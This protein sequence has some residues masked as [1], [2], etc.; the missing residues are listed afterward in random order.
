MA[1]L[2]E[3]RRQRQLRARID[4]KRRWEEAL[5]AQEG[6]LR[7]QE[8]SRI[9]EERRLDEGRRWEEA[10]RAQESSRSEGAA[11]QEN[12]SQ[13]TALPSVLDMAR[14]LEDE[15]RRAQEADE[16]RRAQEAAVRS[17]LEKDLQRAKR[18]AAVKAMLQAEDNRVDGWADE[19]I[20]LEEE[21]G[22]A[23]L[24]D[25]SERLEKEWR[26]SQ[27]AAEEDR[28][29]DEKDRTQKWAVE[30]EMQKHK[31]APAPAANRGTETDVILLGP[32]GQ[33]AVGAEESIESFV[34]P[35]DDKK[36]A[37]DVR[38]IKQSLS[39]AF[40]SETIDDVKLDALVRA[41]RP[42]QFDSFTEICRQGDLE[43]C[44]YIIKSGKVKF[45]VDGEEVGAAGVGHSFGG[46]AL[47]ESPT[48]RTSSAL[49]YGGAVQ[50][51]RAEGADF[52][53]VPNY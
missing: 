19:M 46:L 38:F 15:R 27:E 47:H 11:R 21:V 10:L 49:A 31:G 50:L 43:D 44:F 16:R 33:M 48:P 14:E 22:C 20:R 52:R 2:E 41:F 32:L 24:A 40:V 35:K 25:K 53:L 29:W 37:E 39:K 28:L 5:R 6:A 7:G 18:D 4:E 9:E 45:E 3:E 12:T 1:A 42:I 26:Q 30:L 13:D 36:T 51:W 17:K 23:L 34:Y 8:S